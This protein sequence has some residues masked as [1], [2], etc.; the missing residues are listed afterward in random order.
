MGW[1][2]EQFLAAG[3]EE[4]SRELAVHLFCVFQGIATVAH[5]ANNPI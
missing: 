1:L 2:E 3:H 5:G 4:D